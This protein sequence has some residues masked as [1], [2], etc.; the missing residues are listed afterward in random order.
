MQNEAMPYI[1][2]KII[3]GHTIH[4]FSFKYQLFTS[5]KQSFMHVQE[6]KHPPKYFDLII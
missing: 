3:I 4:A 6:M 5:K 1:W 2:K